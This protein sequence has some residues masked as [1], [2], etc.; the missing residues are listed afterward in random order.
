[1]ETLITA[2][3]GTKCS[4]WGSRRNAREVRVGNNSATPS[5]RTRHLAGSARLRGLLDGTGT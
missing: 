4:G 3:S 1:M 2:S 5:Q